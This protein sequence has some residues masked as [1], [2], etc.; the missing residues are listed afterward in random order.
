MAY[1]SVI[2][3]YAVKSHCLGSRVD[4]EGTNQLCHS[5][6][7]R[8]AGVLASESDS[9]TCREILAC[10]DGRGCVDL[11]ATCCSTSEKMAQSYSPRSLRGCG[12]HLYNLVRLV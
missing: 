8:T 12:V 1:E 9:D 7:E 3:L 2:A 11:P 10:E 6:P 4:V 5:T